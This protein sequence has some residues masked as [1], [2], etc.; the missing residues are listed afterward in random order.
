LLLE[1]VEK[2]GEI[3][4][5]WQHEVTDLVLR[6]DEGVTL[7]CQT[8]EGPLDVDAGWVVACDGA[9]SAVRRL[10]GIGFP[11]HDHSDRF[12]IAD[13]RV[14]L[15]FPTERRF[16]FDPPFNPGRQVL[17]H[18]QP[19]GIWRFDW[20]VPADVDAQE[21]RRNGRLDE[22]I[23]AIV[24]GAPYDLVW[25]SSYRF[26]QRLAERF[27]SGRVLLAGDA[28]HLMSPFGARGMNSGISDGENLV[29][30]LALVVDGQA[31]E[32][33][34]DSYEAERRAAAKEN[35]AVTDATM[36]FMVPP[37]RPRRW[38]R[39]AILRAS[40]LPAARRLVDSGRLAVPFDYA[41][42]SPIVQPQAGRLAADVPCRLPGDMQPRRLREL[43][44][45][46][47]LAVAWE[48]QPGHAGELLERARR[49]APRVPTRTLVLRDDAE[50][51]LAG[52]WYV[53]RPDGYLGAGPVAADQPLGPVVDGC[54]G[55]AA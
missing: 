54:A 50:G 21:E 47:F 29:W 7:R 15:P 11:G 25:L 24:G 17:I 33:L 14:D 52:S 51:Y 5:R 45:P 44:G 34:L 37:S 38:L 42:V 26:S 2:L 6:G 32:A 16:F 18:P 23:R 1:Q 35:L 31:P 28:A 43:V 27:R 46:E 8:P 4:V 55:L 13:V 9:R 20:Q 53:V 41:S 48:A 39:N 10:A 40:V 30:K 3:E 22:R 36:R 19:D 12:L 49:V